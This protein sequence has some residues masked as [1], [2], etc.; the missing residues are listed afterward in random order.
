MA[1]F[2]YTVSGIK[3]FEPVEKR[4]TRE[5][6]ITLKNVKK[7]FTDDAAKHLVA[8]ED[9]NLEIVSGEFFIMLG[10]SGSGKST[11]LRI[12]SGLERDYQGA[13]SYGGGNTEKDFSFVFQHFAILPWL[14]VSQNIELGLIGRNVVEAE[15]TKVVLRELRIFGLEHFAKSYPHEL[16]GGMRQRV[17]IARALATNPKIIFMDEPFSEIDSFTAEELRKEL[18]SIWQERRPTIVMVTHMVDE[19]IELADRIAVL[20]KRPGRIEAIVANS[21]PR[22]RQM[23]STS[24][25]ELEDKLRALIKP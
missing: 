21:L 12:M 20:T 25:Y 9:I 7:V 22:P 18:L 1:G 23:R 4:M 3:Y 11:I 16:S 17:G 24:F 15:R 13:V 6:L 14:T 8:V 19:A 2:R 5:A 10:P